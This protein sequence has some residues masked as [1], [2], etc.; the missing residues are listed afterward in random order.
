MLQDDLQIKVQGSQI[1]R[2][3]GYL[4]SGPDVSQHGEKA[5]NQL[6]LTADPITMVSDGLHAAEYFAATFWSEDRHATD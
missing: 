4:S 6:L 1:I 3:L 5:A 2:W